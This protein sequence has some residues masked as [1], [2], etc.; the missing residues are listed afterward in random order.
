MFLCTRRSDWLLM[1]KSSRPQMRNCRPHADCHPGAIAYVASEYGTKVLLVG[2]KDYRETCHHR[3]N[4]TR[5]ST[6][7]TYRTSDWRG[8]LVGLNSEY[9]TPHDM[10]LVR[11]RMF[12]TQDRVSL[13]TK[14]RPLN[15]KKMAYKGSARPLL[16]Q[17]LIHRASTPTI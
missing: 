4:F 17:C 12:A 10:L 9:S 7:R 5:H 8:I 13:P 14:R 15:E 16:T 2:L 11:S 1:T 3:W 6:S